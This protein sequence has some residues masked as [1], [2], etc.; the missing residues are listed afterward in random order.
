MG[1]KKYPHTRLLASPRC[2]QRTVCRPRKSRN[3]RQGLNGHRLCGVEEVDWFGGGRRYRRGLLR[4][5]ESKSRIC[6]SSIVYAAV[7]PV[8]ERLSELCLDPVQRGLVGVV[9]IACRVRQLIFVHWGL[10]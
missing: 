2:R 7:A 3:A 1:R 9:L 4:E 8:L 5:E 6:H 10:N